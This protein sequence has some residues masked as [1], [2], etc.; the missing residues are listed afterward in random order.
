MAEQVAPQAMP[1]GLAVTVPEPVLVT[2]ST[3]V[4]RV[5]AAP[6]VAAAFMGTVQVAAVPE[7]APLQPVKVE[8]VA[9]A[10]VSVTEVPA[11]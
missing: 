6:T 2:V 8:P 10:A 1:V 7:Q 9:A 4:L 5:K 11:V 3:A